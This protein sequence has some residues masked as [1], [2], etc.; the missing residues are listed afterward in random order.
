MKCNPL[1]YYVHDDDDDVDIGE[2]QRTAAMQTARVTLPG[3][4][5]GCG[6]ETVEGRTK[7]LQKH[8]RLGLRR[9]SG[10]R[11]SDRP[12]VQGRRHRVQR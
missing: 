1:L 7:L 3:D 11:Q 10:R 9:E 12:E 2:R 5:G 6:A 8:R 4:G